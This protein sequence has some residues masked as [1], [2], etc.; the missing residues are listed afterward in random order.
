MHDELSPLA[1]F[2]KKQVNSIVRRLTG[3]KTHYDAQRYVCTDEVSGR[4]QADI[5]IK[6]G[7]NTSSKV[8]EVGCGCL[9]AGLYLIEMLKPEH[10]VGIDPNEWLRETA[11]RKPEVSRMAAVKKPVFLSNEDFDAT[12]S[13][14]TFDFVLSHSILSHAAHWQLPLF[15]D[16]V[17]AV[18]APTGKI[19]ASLYVA[20]G[21]PYG[22]Q[23]SPDHQDSMDESWVYPG[24]SW[25]TLETIEET[26]AKYGLN[27][28]R[29]LEHTRDI[30]AKRPLEM[31]DWFVFERCS[32][33]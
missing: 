16:K 14:L 21:N 25:F 24:I 9:S 5:L 22:S 15:L 6:E 27:A 30:V 18:L 10:Y 23:G 7:C 31:H 11:L 1:L 13:G 26:A 20:E 4:M 17:S 12:S 28:N 32:L 2:T 33:K 3:R 19:V 8:L 29:R